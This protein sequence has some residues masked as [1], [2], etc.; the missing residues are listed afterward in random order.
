[1]V[2]IMSERKLNPKQLRYITLGAVVIIGVLVILYTGGFLSIIQPSGPK[3]GI[4]YG[5]VVFYDPIAD[6]Y[7]EGTYSLVEVS[8]TS[9]F[10]DISVDSGDVI[11][12]TKECIAVFN[13]TGIDGFPDYTF[14]PES[15]A[16]EAGETEDDSVKNVISLKRIASNSD[17]SVTIYKLNGAY[18]IFT[19][20]DI[21]NKASVSMEVN[22]KNTDN[23]T[24]VGCFTWLPEAFVSDEAFALNQSGWGFWMAFVGV[25]ENPIKGNVSYLDGIDGSVITDGIVS[26]IPIIAEKASDYTFSLAFEDTVA[27]DKIV[28]Y[29]G[30]IVD[31]DN[32]S[33]TLEVIP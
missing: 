18:G 1:V 21:S 7:Y 14:F 3:Q 24:Y 15:L 12:T 29:Y 22:I 6:E 28:I 27:I 16:F 13:G 33:R 26:I 2:E 32:L 31:Y 19:A 11:R 23:D 30:E 9:E 5:S 10:Y 4:G 17:V 25:S 8:N 20:N